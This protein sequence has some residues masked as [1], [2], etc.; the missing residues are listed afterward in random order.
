MLLY[1]NIMNYNYI[2]LHQRNKNVLKRNN[3]YENKL[4]LI[5]EEDE[6]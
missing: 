2:G 1:T 5:K 6:K 4:S 3:D